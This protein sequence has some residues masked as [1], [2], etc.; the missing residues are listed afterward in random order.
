MAMN[1]LGTGLNDAEHHEDALTVREAEL[2]AMRRLGAPEEH[3]LIA[4]GN[5]ATAYQ[6]LGRR[7]EALSM[8][9]DVYSGRL[10]LTGEEHESTLRAASNYASSLV[11]LQRFEES[12]PVLRK[13]MPVARRVLGES[14]ELTLKMRGLYAEALYK[15]DGATRDDLR[16]AVSTLEDAERIARRVLG[17]AHPFTEGVVGSLQEV[18]AALRARETP[19][20]SP[21]AESRK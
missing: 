17:S 1:L 12:K 15:A 2:S 4:Q 6:R 14:H 13:T 8:R 7:E 11:D 16:V 3:M 9:R 10:K 18:R 19:S 21:Q 5:L 20:T